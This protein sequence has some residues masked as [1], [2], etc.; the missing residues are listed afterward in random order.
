MTSEIIRKGWLWKRGAVNKAYKKR[1]FRMHAMSLSYYVDE[2]AKKM[3]GAINLEGAILVDAR[4]ENEHKWGFTLVSGQRAYVL[5]AL[6]E[7]DFE[8]W[9]TILRKITGGEAAMLREEVRRLIDEVERLHKVYIVEKRKSRE[10]QAQL[11]SLTGADTKREMSEQ[12]ATSQVEAADLKDAVA[13]K[14]GSIARLQEKLDKADQALDESK[15]RLAEAEA[16]AE[17]AEAKA[18]AARAD[19]EAKA[20]EVAKNDARMG[21]ALRWAAWSVSQKSLAPLLEGRSD[22][23]QI[24]SVC[25]EELDPKTT[26]LLQKKVDVH[27]QFMVVDATGMPLGSAARTPP[28]AYNSPLQLLLPTGYVPEAY[29]VLRI[30]H[31][32]KKMVTMRDKASSRSI[33]QEFYKNSL[34]AWGYISLVGLQPGTQYSVQMLKKPVDFSRDPQVISK[35][36]PSQVATVSIKNVSGDGKASA[37][38]GKGGVAESGAGARASSVQ[39]AWGNHLEAFM[40]RNA[41]KL[42]RDYDAKSVVACVDASVRQKTSYE[43]QDG[44]EKCYSFIWERMAES[45]RVEIQLLQ[46]D[47]E[48]RTVFFCWRC[49]GSGFEAATTTLIFSPE[50]RVIRQTILLVPDTKAEGTQEPSTPASVG[51]SPVESSAPAASASASAAAAA[52]PEPAAQAAKPVAAPA[53]GGEG[54]A[55]RTFLM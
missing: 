15:K 31:M 12:L 51:P 50:F 2:F 10:L 39:D 32:K 42:L 13:T 55:T 11:S 44:A 38:D 24:L 36:G 26:K 34:I 4:E 22:D 27:C 48:A 35:F 5:K 54:T 17:A 25:V 9:R 6:D 52:A 47:E 40:Q 28:E 33:R 43:G 8:D 45:A 16:K 20:K 29:L 37:K 30:F 18:K 14:V 41:K 21:L 49:A 23:Y 46:V 19:A 1:Y 7:D 3:Q 53:D